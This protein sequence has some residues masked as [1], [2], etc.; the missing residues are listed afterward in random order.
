M[1]DILDI[2]LTQLDQELT[3]RNLK[4]EIVIC[5]A[6]AIHLLG[7]TRSEHTLDVDSITELNSNEIKQIVEAIGQKLGLGSHRLN[8]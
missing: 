5:G 8:D 6:Y 1:A 2:A 3:Q 7:Y 4:T